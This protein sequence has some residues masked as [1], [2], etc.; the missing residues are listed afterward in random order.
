QPNRTVL[1]ALAFFSVG[2]SI[3]MAL[4]PL[5]Q[6][7][8]SAYAHAPSVVTAF[9][10]ATSTKVSVY[11]LLRVIFTVY[12]PSFAIVRLK[13]DAG[14]LMLALAGIYAASLAAIFQ[15]DVKRLL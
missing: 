14:L 13:F 6:W 9:L 2:I 11:V 5:H 4:F 3:K 8:P 7:L 10:A 12:P 1:V 15:K